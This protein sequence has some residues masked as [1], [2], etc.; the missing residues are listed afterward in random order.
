MTKN[1]RANLSVFPARETLPSPMA[2]RSALWALGVAR[3]ISSAKSIFVNIGPFFKRKLSLAGTNIS[4]PRISEGIISFV[5]WILAKSH[6][7]TLAVA[8]ARVV[9]PVPGKSSKRM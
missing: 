3:L 4:V 9:L 1:G 2:S 6:P 5:N 7:I 8:M